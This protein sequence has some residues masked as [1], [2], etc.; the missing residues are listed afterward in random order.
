MQ[1][2]GEGPETLSGDLGRFRLLFDSQNYLQSGAQSASRWCWGDAG[3]SFDTLGQVSSAEPQNLRAVGASP[4]DAHWDAF[5]SGVLP[6][7]AA[8]REGGGPLASFLSSWLSTSSLCLPSLPPL[9]LH[10]HL[11]LF[12][13][14]F[15]F[16]PSLQPSIPPSIHPSS[17]SLHCLPLWLSVFISGSLWVSLSH[18][19]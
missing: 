18:P 6:G 12:P 13:P 14:L 8:G 3:G 1:G 15:S 4:P 10:L 11:P 7:V 2:T 5:V 19:P 9:P 16:S 17:L